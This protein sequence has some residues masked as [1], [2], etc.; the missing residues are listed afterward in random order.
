MRKVILIG[1]T[2]ALGLMVLAS[3][4]SLRHG[5]KDG[6]EPGYTGSPGDSLKNC[7]ACHGG[8]AV[9]VDGWIASTIPAEGYTP[10]ERYTIIATNTEMGATRFGFSISPQNIAGDLLGTMVITDTLRTKL[11]GNN[12]YATYREAG[13]EGKDSL[14]WFFDWIAPAEGT[15][16]VTFYGAFNSNHEGHK[17]G[18]QTTLST[19][20]VR[21]KWKTGLGKTFGQRTGFS[22]FPNPAQAFTTVTF[23]ANFSGNALV[24]VVDMWGKQYAH[25]IVTQQSGLVNQQINTENLPAGN[26]LVRLM[27]DGE[28]AV[29][30]IVVAH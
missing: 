18:D 29:Q 26:Y 15:G 5:K 16:N 9:T 2:S 17:D 3:F 28:T 30:R 4:E 14:K 22:V 12:K 10:G 6:T 8:R 25:V 7:T 21:E 11:V 23:H 20:T 24:D 27:A 19:L 1:V 13:V